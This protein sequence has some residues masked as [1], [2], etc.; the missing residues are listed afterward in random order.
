MVLLL[1]ECD[2]CGEQQECVQLVVQDFAENPEG[3]PDYES[4]NVCASCIANMWA[5]EETF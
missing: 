3:Y 2:R 1:G 5:L 4:S